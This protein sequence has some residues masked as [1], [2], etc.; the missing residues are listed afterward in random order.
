MGLNAQDVVHKLNF[1]SSDEDLY[2]YLKGETLFQ[3]GKKGWKLITVEGYPLGWAKQVQG[4]LK[5][6]YPPG[7]RRL[8]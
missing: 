7:W 1:S 8:A 6:A 3:E 5:N 4:F 2:R